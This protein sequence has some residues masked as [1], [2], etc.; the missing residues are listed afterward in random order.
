MNARRIAVTVGLALGLLGSGSAAA[1]QEATPAASPVGPP[2][3]PE[4][5]TVI[6]S[7]LANPRYVAVGDDGTVYISE[8]G[9]GGDVVVTRPTA[10][11]ATPV[12]G[13]AGEPLAIGVGTTGQ[14]TMVAPDGTQSGLVGELPSFSVNAV[15]AAG[16]AGIKVANGQVLLAIGGPATGA[17]FTE[18][19]PNEASVVSI[20]PATGE[21]TLVADIGA[22]ERANNPDGFAIDTNLYGIGVADDG[23]IYVAGAGGNATYRIPPGGEP[24]VLVVHAGLP[25]PEGMEAPPG[26]NPNRDGANE[27]DPVPT[28]IEFGADSTVLVGLL[29]GGPFPPGA[30][31]VVS[32][33]QDG[34]VSDVATGLTMVVALA[35]GPDGQLYATQISTDFLGEMPAPGNVVRLLADGTQEVVVDGLILPNGIAF[36]ADGNLLVVV[37]TVSIGGPTGQVLRCEGVATTASAPANELTVELSE[38]LY[39]PSDISIAANTD[40]TLRLVNSGVAS[41]DFSIGALGVSSGTV[42]AGEEVTLTVNVPAGDYAFGCSV[43]GHSLAGMTGVLRAE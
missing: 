24:E 19:V 43:A 12:A 22:Y 41:H 23:T 36:D 17:A 42:A 16:P 7:G 11:G 31:K 33:A 27:L 9:V 4:N 14:V 10:A 2:P 29:S 13:P 28:G 40:V 26:G 8:A 38:M 35:V 21:V 32:V 39:T 34:T 37:N 30:A 20:D 1:L 18:P 25:L 3:I 6:A 5:C 15:E